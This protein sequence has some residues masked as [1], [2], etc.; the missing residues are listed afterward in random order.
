MSQNNVAVKLNSE[1]YCEVQHVPGKN[2]EPWLTCISVFV[3]G[4][5][6]AIGTVAGRLNHQQALKEFYR[7]IDGKGGKNPFKWMSEGAPLA[8][9]LRLIPQLPAEKEA[10]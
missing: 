6:V 9:M 2:R 1:L 5:Q 10:A 7:R 4:K 8:R 3:D